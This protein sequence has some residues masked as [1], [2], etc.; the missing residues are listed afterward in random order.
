MDDNPRTCSVCG[1][2]SARLRRV[3]HYLSLFF[4]PL[5]PVKRGEPFLEC[6]RC[7]G[8]FDPQGGRLREDAWGQRRRCPSCGRGLEPDHR[9][10]PYC[11]TRV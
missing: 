5:F 4:I 1:L 7:Q 6:D 3:D 8:L 10:C 9:F 2:P 11:G